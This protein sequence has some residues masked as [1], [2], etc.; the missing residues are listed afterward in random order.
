MTTL[1]EHKQQVQRE[2]LRAAAFT[3]FARDGYAETSVTDIC[4][5]SEPP[6]SSPT[7]YR[8]FASKA[9]L[10]VEWARGALPVLEVLTIMIGDPSIAATLVEWVREEAEAR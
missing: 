10:Y 1:R 3:C 2:A 4:R 7:F 6:C 8:Y 9:E 5:A